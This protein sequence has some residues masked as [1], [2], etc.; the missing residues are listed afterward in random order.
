[1]ERLIF[2]HG[3]IIEVTNDYRKMR[4]KPMLRL[5]PYNK[6]IEGNRRKMMRSQPIK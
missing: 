1:M 5:I 3:N 6:C 4:N 2:K